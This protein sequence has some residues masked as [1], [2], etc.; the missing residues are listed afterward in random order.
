MEEAKQ[1][2]QDSLLGKHRVKGIE[3]ESDRNPTPSLKPQASIRMPRAMK[4]AGSQSVIKLLGGPPPMEGKEL[5]EA[6]LK[7]ATLLDAGNEETFTLEPF[8]HLLEL[9][10]SRDKS[11]L[12]AR[13]MT[14]DPQN[15]EHPFFSFYA[16]H[17]INKILFRTEQQRNLL[18]RMRARNPL[19]NMLIVGD[20]HYF[21][22]TP[23]AYT[24]GLMRGKPSNVPA[25]EKAVSDDGNMKSALTTGHRRSHSD[26]SLGTKLHRSHSNTSL[27]MQPVKSKPN[28]Q[29]VCF[30][31]QF[32]AT[33]EDFLHRSETRELFFQNSIHADD[34]TLFPLYLDGHVAISMP[35]GAPYTPGG[36]LDPRPAISWRNCCGIIN[37]R[38]TP[39]LTNNY[40]G[41]IT[42]GGAIP[43]TLL[44]AA[45]CVVL[46]K[47]VIPPPFMFLA[48]FIMLFVAIVVALFFVEYPVGRRRFRRNGRSERSAR[49]Q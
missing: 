16:A 32:I 47:F 35:E 14:V 41:F 27:T 33:D 39:S 12:I 4:E 46:V 15:S 2:S 31:A 7:A 1:S 23:M 8:E 18:H 6:A 3:I 43:L 17:H 34:F 13:V 48:I 21:E 40:T 9:A 22:I 45:G 44:Y 10:A 11:L 25:Q 26:T 28:L 19:N 5:D 29:E 30:E 49:T 36:A 38:P 42:V 24:K 37:T 20:V